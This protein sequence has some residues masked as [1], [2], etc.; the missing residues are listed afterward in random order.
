[1][2]KKDLRKCDICLKEYDTNLTDVNVK[3]GD[4]LNDSKTIWKCQY[5][6]HEEFKNK[7]EMIK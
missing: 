1:M 3:N 7:Y 4:V 6:E 2:E 5:C